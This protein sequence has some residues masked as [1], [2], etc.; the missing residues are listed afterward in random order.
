MSDY[1]YRFTG[2]PFVDAGIAALCAFNKRDDPQAITKEDLRRSI[3]F[4]SNRYPTW[5]KLG[6]F[7]TQN[8]LPLQPSL[9]MAER[10]PRYRKY[11]ESLWNNIV[12]ISISGDCGACGGRKAENLVRRDQYPLT[13]SGEMVNYFSFF[14][15]GFPICSACIFAVQ[16]APLF[17]MSNKD[18]ILK[19]RDIKTGKIKRIPIPQ[20]LF[21]VHTHR[22]EIMLDLA[23]DSLYY[24]KG[25]IA[26][27]EPP[28]FYTRFPIRDRYGYEGIVKLAR[29]IVSRSTAYGPTSVRLYSFTNSGQVNRLDF[30]DLPVDVFSFLED[31][32]KGKGL[33]REIGE[34]FANSG[35]SIYQRLVNGET[36]RNFFLSKKERKIYGGWSLFELYIGEVEKMKEERIKAMKS[37]GQRLYQYLKD[38][39]FKRLNDLEL[40]EKNYSQFLTLL[41][42]I[43]KERLIWEIGEYSL[44]FPESDEGIIQ[45]RETKDIL[46]SYIYE[47]MHRD[48]INPKEV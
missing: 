18:R 40:A 24:L 21:L 36:I 34:L 17:I 13:G 20:S 47:Q 41:T 33:T 7:F 23:K 37:V 39:N 26:K 14:E 12:P 4:I 11:L 48:G 25:N 5:R 32:I 45:W 22:K 30:I 6:N 9:K 28:S 27:G 16:F 10:G 43:Q 44:L 46:L 2:N 31:A 1:I 3:D 42:K 29:E 19:E 8:C 38:T 15:P 35:R